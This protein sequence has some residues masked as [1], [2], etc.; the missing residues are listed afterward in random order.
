MTNRSGRSDTA[1]PARDKRM[2]DATKTLQKPEKQAVEKA[3]DA[4]IKVYGPA[5]KELEKH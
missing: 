1:H 5:L 4:I 3:V 2:T